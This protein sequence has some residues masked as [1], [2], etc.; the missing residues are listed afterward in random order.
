MTSSSSHLANFSVRHDGTTE[1]K[2]LKIIS[3]LWHNVHTE[4]PSSHSPIIEYACRRISDVKWF[5]SV[6][7]G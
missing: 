3:Y 7:L 5:G 4:F 1:C 6:R 2:K